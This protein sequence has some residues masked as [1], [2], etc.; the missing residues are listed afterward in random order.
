[1][2]FTRPL[3]SCLFEIVTAYF[4]PISQQIVKT[5]KGPLNSGT[6]LTFLFN[7]SYHRDINVIYEFILNNEIDTDTNRTCIKITCD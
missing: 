7:I 4:N 5:G 3:I 1:M 6:A 2:K